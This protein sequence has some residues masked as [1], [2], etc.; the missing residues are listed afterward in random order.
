MGHGACLISAL[1]QFHRLAQAARQSDIMGMNP[2]DAP[3]RFRTLAQRYRSAPRLL[4]LFFEQAG[5]GALIGLM[6]AAALVYN[7]IANLHSLIFG[8]DI[9]LAA[10]MLFFF[11]FALTFAA[12]M[13][14]TAMLLN[15]E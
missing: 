4:R 8:S 3:N 7:N 5:L 6:L 9:W 2:S 10:S 12:A 11:T 13:I 15:I 14:A 1:R